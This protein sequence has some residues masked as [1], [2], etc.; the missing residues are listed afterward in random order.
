MTGVDIYFG[1]AVDENDDDDDNDDED[2]DD[3]DNGPS[4][5]QEYEK[6]RWNL[7][8]RFRDDRGSNQL[9]PE[10]FDLI[11]SRLLAEGINASRWSSYVRELKQ[12]L[13]PGGWLQMVELE[14]LIQSSAGLLNENS[15]L[16]RWWQC[17][18]STM[19][20][21]GK[22]PRIGRELRQYLQTE[23]FTH[24]HG[25]TIDL[26]IGSWRSGVSEASHFTAST[27]H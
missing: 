8:A 3:N 13:K 11:N 22:N 12:M 9:R 25:G 27:V 1:R 6:K 15:H 10:S 4:P 26:P 24:L 18:S 19:Q 2:D 21:M 16:T 5:V 20:R 23:G 7:N 17:Y 14:P